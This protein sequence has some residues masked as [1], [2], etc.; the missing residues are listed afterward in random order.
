MAELI[1]YWL[2]ESEGNSMWKLPNSDVF[3]RFKN[4][5]Y[6]VAVLMIDNDVDLNL[7]ND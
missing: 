6:N 3:A 5:T 7:H 2:C 4:E 1:F